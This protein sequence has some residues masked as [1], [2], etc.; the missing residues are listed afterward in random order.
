MKKRIRRRSPHQ[1]IP[2]TD[3]AFT[4]Y[5]TALGQL[6][7][8]WNGLHEML[9]ILFCNVMGNGVVNQPLAIWHAL[10]VDRAQREILLAALKS[11]TR[12]AYP[13]DFEPDIEWICKKAD[14]LEDLR[15]DALHSPLWAQERA[16]GKTIV[17]AWVGL[18][19]VRA[20]KLLNKDLLAEFR[21]FRDAAMLLAE[22]AHEV[23]RSLSDYMRPWPKRPAWPARPGTNAPKQPRPT[24]Q[25]KH[26]R[27]PQSSGA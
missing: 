4:P 6:A 12:G 11:H 13:V 25:A 23:D 10:K 20:Q 8:A 15:N 9:S 17:S 21:W 2:Y 14:S 16:P 18:G 19:H 1:G 27:R 22:F 3:K 5:V 24:P 26:S 7:L